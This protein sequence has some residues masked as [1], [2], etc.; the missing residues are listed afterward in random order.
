MT[1]IRNFFSPT[2]TSLAMT[3]SPVKIEMKSIAVRPD[4]KL[5]VS[6]MKS[7]INSVKL[8]KKHKKRKRKVNET[9]EIH[10]ISNILQSNLSFISPNR[11]EPQLNGKDE[12]QKGQCWM[13]KKNFKME[14]KFFVE[15][16]RNRKH[17][18]IRTE[19]CR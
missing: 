15:Y 19:Y 4:N 8:H 9:P 16:F 7:V 18:H 13:N 2:K 1:S 10:D 14:I 3:P 11:T 12:I 5:I 17:H 6:N